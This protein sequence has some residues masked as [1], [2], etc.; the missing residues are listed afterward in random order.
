MAKLVHHKHQSN[1]VNLDQV[2][3]IH[4]SKGEGGGGTIHFIKLIPIG[5]HIHQTPIASWQFNEVIEAEKLLDDLV[6]TYGI[7]YPS[8]IDTFIEKLHTPD[9]LKGQAHNH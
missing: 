5:D 8:S 6:K 2:D 9:P 7:T 4:L 1:I 3:F